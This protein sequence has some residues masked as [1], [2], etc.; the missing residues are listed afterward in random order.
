MYTTKSRIQ[1]FLM[2]NIDDS[3]EE[4][5]NEWI[6]V[7]TNFIDNYTGTTFE[8]DNDTYRLYDGDGSKEILVDDFT[9]FTKIEILDEDGNVNYTIDRSTEY[10]AY[11][12]NK[13][14]K[15]R[16]VL[17]SSNAPIGHFPK[18]NLNVKLYATFGRSADVPDDIRHV[19]T[20]L[21]AGI[22]EEKNIDIAGNI[23]SETLGE[24]SV[25]LQDLDK[26]GRRLKVYDILDRYRIYHV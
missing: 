21:V 23:K 4:E 17:E 16:I 8:S 10:Y 6:S 2:I 15:N 22:I 12:A 7:A 25:T 3:F 9:T 18:G 14:Y 26:I 11:P 13:D 24:Y 5:I 19:A 1:N 20:M